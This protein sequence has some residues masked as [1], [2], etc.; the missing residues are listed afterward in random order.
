MRRWERAAAVE[1]GIR[2]VGTYLLIGG[3]V[4]FLTPWFF[5]STWPEWI[6]VPGAVAGLGA[7]LHFV[8]GM[9]PTGDYPPTPQE[10]A[11][12]KAEL[13]ESLPHR[14]RLAQSTD[15]PK[16][17]LRDLAQNDPNAEVR[18]A[19]IETLALLRQAGL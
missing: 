1:D 11:G 8:A 2:R 16:M 6:I 4:V 10:I 15:T 7:L 17:D 9:W 18:R 12:R 13:R 5:T 19:A 3:I 14:L